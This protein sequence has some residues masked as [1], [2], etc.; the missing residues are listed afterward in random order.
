MSADM[1]TNCHLAT[2]GSYELEVV[3]CNGCGFHL[4]IDATYLEQVGDVV[5][6]CPSCGITLSIDGDEDAGVAV[7]HHAESPGSPESLLKAAH[8]LL[9]GIWEPDDLDRARF[10]RRLAA[11]NPEGNE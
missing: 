6:K 9:T 11:Y 10:V 3:E 1:T 7:A 8:E 4:G 5:L 2:E